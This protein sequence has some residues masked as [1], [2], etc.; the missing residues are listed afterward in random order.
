MRHPRGHYPALKTGAGRRTA[1]ATAAPDVETLPCPAGGIHR[2]A[3][4]S[5]RG[6]LVTACVGCGKSWSE[7]DEAARRP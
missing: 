3:N 1:K 7:I 6:G 2:L 4:S 5:A